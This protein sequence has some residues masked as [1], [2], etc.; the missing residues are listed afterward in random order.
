MQLEHRGIGFE[1]ESESNSLESESFVFE[2]AG[3][4]SR[5]L[6]SDS[7]RA[8]V[9]EEISDSRSHS[10]SGYRPSGVKLTAS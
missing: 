9:P 3:L 4:Q 1:F 5:R 8:L 7:D 6:S 2:P 10:S